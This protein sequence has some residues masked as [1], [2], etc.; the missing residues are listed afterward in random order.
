MWDKRVE[1]FW[2]IK[3]NCETN[4]LVFSE[5]SNT[6]SPSA[7]VVRKRIVTVIFGL[8]YNFFLFLRM[9]FAGFFRTGAWKFRFVILIFFGFFSTGCGNESGTCALPL[10]VCRGGIIRRLPSVSRAQILLFAGRFFGRLLNIVSSV[11]PIDCFLPWKYLSLN[12]FTD[13][14]SCFY[15]YMII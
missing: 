14:A 15:P 11:F 7:E 1:D 9:E 12:G 3:K 4:L 10:S 5:N 2:W 13:S 6:R 8:F